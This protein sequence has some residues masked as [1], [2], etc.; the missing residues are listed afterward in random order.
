M[1]LIIDSREPKK[2]KTRLI[3]KYGKAHNITIDTLT[4]GDYLSKTVICE[5]KTVGDLY[6]SIIDKR[7]WSQ[8]NRMST[9]E[10]KTKIILVTGSIK[11]FE[12]MLRRKKKFI[13]H[14]MLHNAIASILRRYDFSIMWIENENDALDILMGY[15]DRSDK[16]DANKPVRADPDVLLSRL[17]SIP[18]KTYKELILNFGSIKNLAAANKKEL[19]NVKGVGEK[20]ATHILEI[21]S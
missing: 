1:E 20:R 4:E 14:K 2:I 13:N 7:L 6:G 19:M 5:R 3:K 17:F 11:A 18:L 15:M 9:Y 10:D 16:G 21:L 8:V 12:A